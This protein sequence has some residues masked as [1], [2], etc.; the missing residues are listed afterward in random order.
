MD[1]KQI[2]DRQ[3]GMCRF[4][5]NYCLDLQIKSYTESKTQFS[6]YTLQQKIALLK[7]QEEFKWLNEGM[8]QALCRETE[9]LDKAFTS[10]FKKKTQFPKF[11]SKKD[12]HKS[13]T[14][15]QHF[16]IEGNKLTLPKA[17]QMKII[18]HRDLPSNHY[19]SC[20]VSKT[21]SGK[22][23]AS[24]NCK[25]PDETVVKKPISE[26]QAIGIDLGIKTFCVL[27]NGTMIENPKYLRKALKKI[28][29]LSRKHSKKQVG[30]INR[31]KSRI[32]LAKAHEKVINQRNDFLH[33]VTNQLTNEFDTICLETLNVAGMVKNHKLALAIS[34]LG[35][36]K[37]NVL[38]DR[39]AKSKGKNIIRI[40]RWEASSKT[41][42]TCGTINKDLELKDRT[43]TCATCNTKHDRDLNAANNIKNMAFAGLERSL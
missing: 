4:I 41:C 31:E 3:F 19:T 33:K 36:E 29:K 24:I 21:P 2:L 9:N 23:F 13:F 40:G 6:K 17:G 7:K 10:F 22:Y 16:K 8:S 1:Q 43:W 11:R 34:D 39:K 5:Y 28:K 15:P 32:Q 18:L 37:F 38:I 27:S 12:N 30:S 20:T 35:I 14:I 26:T 42:G 25:V